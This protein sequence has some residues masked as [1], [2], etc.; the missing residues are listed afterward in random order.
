MNA[1]S[2]V[3]GWMERE[4][5]AFPGRACPGPTGKRNE[6]FRI[7]RGNSTG[8]AV[9]NRPTYDAVAAGGIGPPIVRSATRTGALCVPKIRKEK[10]IARF[11]Q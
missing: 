7:R 10:E 1:R 8:V 6:K 4:Y 3:A 9:P 11:R 2:L 5:S